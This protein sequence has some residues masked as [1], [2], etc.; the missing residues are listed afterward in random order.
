MV[1]IYDYGHDYLCLDERYLSLPWMQ[2]FSSFCPQ[3]LTRRVF[4]GVT[5]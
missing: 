4:S 2:R 1:V 3:V 5:L